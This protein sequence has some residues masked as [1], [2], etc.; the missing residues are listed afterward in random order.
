MIQQEIYTAPKVDALPLYS[1]IE[2]PS[3]VG[4]LY[5]YYGTHNSIKK[6]WY[7]SDTI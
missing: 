2:K 7:L 1:V 3:T 4:A 5:F 6:I